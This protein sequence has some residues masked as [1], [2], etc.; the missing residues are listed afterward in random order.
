MKVGGVGWGVDSCAVVVKQKPKGKEA[1]L[2][3]EKV[4]KGGRQ[5][6]LQGFDVTTKW[7]GPNWFDKL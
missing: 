5:S 6:Q 2:R 3:P 1:K 7:V 4:K